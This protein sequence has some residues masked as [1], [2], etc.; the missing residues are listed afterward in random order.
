V[1]TSKRQ[2]LRMLEREREAHAAERAR[3][4]DQICNLSGRPWSPAPASM[5]TVTDEERARQA[6]E[7]RARR[8]RFTARPELDPD[9]PVLVESE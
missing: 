2:L 5:P 7:R 8:R 6:Q 9:F 3:L 1:G 4:I